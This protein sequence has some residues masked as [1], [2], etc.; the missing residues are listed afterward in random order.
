MAGAMTHE[1]SRD[2]E[3]LSRPESNEPAFTTDD[4]AVPPPD[5]RWSEIVT[6]L[7]T[8]QPVAIPA[9]FRQRVMRRIARENLRHDFLFALQA[10]AV[11]GAIVIGL[12]ASILGSTWW[13][14][15]LH[16]TRSGAMS[17]FYETLL[18]RMIYAVRASALLAGHTRAFWSFMPVA[19]LVIACCAAVAQ[20]TVF[21]VFLR[22]D[23][24]HP[25]IQPLQPHA[26]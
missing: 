11:T 14:L 12:I 1:N 4:E 7:A 17:V 19:L 13:P 16:T 5:S 8:T 3:D 24:S 9:E 25:A 26:S 18:T 20:F 10:G 23:H 2:P 22:A 21:R 15:L 6:H